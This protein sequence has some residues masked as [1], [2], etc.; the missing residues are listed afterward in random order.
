MGYEDAVCALLRFDPL[1]YY[2]HA[3]PILDMSVPAPLFPDKLN[4]YVRHSLFANRS[5]VSVYVK[6]D[7]FYFAF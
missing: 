3:S 4:M 5:S 6:Y 2:W 1:L 7:K